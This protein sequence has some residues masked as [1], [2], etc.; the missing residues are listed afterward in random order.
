MW[1]GVASSARVLS[2]RRLTWERAAA[3]IRAR[4]TA[5]LTRM[6]AALSAAP[7][8]PSSQVL[9]LIDNFKFTD[10]EIAFLRCV[11]RH[12][13]LHTTR[14]TMPLCHTLSS[15]AGSHGTGIDTAAGPR[16]RTPRTSSLSTSQP[17]TAPR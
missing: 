7:P 9:R 5:T 13:P 15:A 1:G 2:S 10:S 6:P 17:W 4:S 3:T 8:W 12:V 14:V 16:F 11:A